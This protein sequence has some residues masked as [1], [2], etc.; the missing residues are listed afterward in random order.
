M[1]DKISGEG[2]SDKWIVLE[3]ARYLS[4]NTGECSLS[5]GDL[6]NSEQCFRHANLLDP[7]NA[8]TWLDLAK[9]FGRK[10]DAAKCNQSLNQYEFLSNGR[11]ATEIYR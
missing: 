4:A 3:D 5:L 10:R 11:K 6:E 8:D 2:L 7:G 9:L 1:L